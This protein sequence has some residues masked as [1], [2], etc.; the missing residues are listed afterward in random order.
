MQILGFLPWR[1]VRYWNGPAVLPPCLQ[2][3]LTGSTE[4]RSTP[5]Q[6]NS[7]IR[8]VAILAREARQARRPTLTVPARGAPPRLQV[9]GPAAR[10][11]K[12]TAQSQKAI[13]DV[14]NSLPAEFFDRT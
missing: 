2:R 14:I 13:D 9:E 11:E 6:G 12:G 10:H 7:T 3:M 5:C 1:E 8:G 4:D